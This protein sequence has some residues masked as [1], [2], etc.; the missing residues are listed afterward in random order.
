M[1]QVLFTA[2][3]CIW[4]SANTEQFENKSAN[5]LFTVM[6]VL[7]SIVAFVFTFALDC[8]S[9]WFLLSFIL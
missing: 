2:E 5:I 8:E 1:F 3:T 4:S 6:P 9:V 7:A